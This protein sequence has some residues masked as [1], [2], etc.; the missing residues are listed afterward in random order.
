MRKPVITAYECPS[1]G[2][3]MPLAGLNF[4]PGRDVFICPMGH[5]REERELKNAPYLTSDGVWHNLDLGVQP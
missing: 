2:K 5:A 4:E 3:K 1:C